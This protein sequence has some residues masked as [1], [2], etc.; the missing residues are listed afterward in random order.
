MQDISGLRYLSRLLILDMSLLGEVAV[1]F[2]STK[3]SER[4]GLE[5][6]EVTNLLII[7]LSKF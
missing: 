4:P 1:R 7:S 6:L 2:L 5:G 3:F